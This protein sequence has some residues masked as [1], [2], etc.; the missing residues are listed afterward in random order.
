MVPR[1]LNLLAIHLLSLGWSHSTLTEVCRDVET[2]GLPKMLAALKSLVLV[3][4]VV[5][6]NL[7]ERSLGVLYKEHIYLAG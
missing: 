3:C 4:E 7:T 2:S 6:Q 5:S 1:K